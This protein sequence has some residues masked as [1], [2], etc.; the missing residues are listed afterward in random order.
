MLTL[1]TDTTPAEYSTTAPVNTVREEEDKITEEEEEEE[2]EEE[3]AERLNSSM[4]DS[5]AQVWFLDAEAEQVEEKRLH[6]FK[7]LLFLLLVD[8]WPCHRSKRA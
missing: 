3:G 8:L 6:K 7:C 2:E 5:A 1:L 4:L